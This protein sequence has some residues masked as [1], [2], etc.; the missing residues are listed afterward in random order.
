M[1]VYD[2]LSEHFTSQYNVSILAELST[3]NGRKEIESVC[4]YYAHYGYENVK[5]GT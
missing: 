2:S 4:E 1:R 3:V 5:V